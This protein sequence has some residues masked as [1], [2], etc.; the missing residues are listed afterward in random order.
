MYHRSDAWR[1]VDAQIKADVSARGPIL[2]S[3]LVL[4][5]SGAKVVPAR[6]RHALERYNHA[7]DTVI[8]R[9]GAWWNEQGRCLE[10]EPTEYRDL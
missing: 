7:N 3:R 6:W 8:R 4:V 2:L 10:F 9:E 1:P 5:R